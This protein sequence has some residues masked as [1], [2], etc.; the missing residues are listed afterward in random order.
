[1]DTGI[2]IITGIGIQAATEITITDNGEHSRLRM[3]EKTYGP[4]PITTSAEA[5]YPT[6][7]PLEILLLIQTG[8]EGRIPAM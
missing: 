8:Q 1:M 5:R 4:Q 2:T 7:E 3:A 6:P